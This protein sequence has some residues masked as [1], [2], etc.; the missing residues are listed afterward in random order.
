MISISVAFCL[1]LLT[2]NENIT[3]E[4]CKTQ[5]CLLLC[6]YKLSFVFERI[7][8]QNLFIVYRLFT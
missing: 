2:R 5:T 7:L 6:D 3:F 4:E 8:L 1:D